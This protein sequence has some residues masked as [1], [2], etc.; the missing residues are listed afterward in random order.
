MIQRRSLLQE[1]AKPRETASAGERVEWLRDQ[2]RLYARDLA[3]LEVFRFLEPEKATT[4]LLLA[5]DGFADQIGATDDVIQAAVEAEQQVSAAIMR[6]MMEQLRRRVF[7]LG[8]EKAPGH[9]VMAA[10]EKVCEQHGIYVPTDVLTHRC[11]GI[12]IAASTPKAWRRRF[13]G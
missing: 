13:V 1:P 9:E 2:I 6:R 5:A 3:V 4:E 11:R 7:S 8:R 12:A 10:A